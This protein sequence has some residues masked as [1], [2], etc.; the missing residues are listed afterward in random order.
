MCSPL[1]GGNATVFGLRCTCP[2][3]SSTKHYTGIREE[4][5][6]PS[7]LNPLKGHLFDTL[8]RPL[9][10]NRR[11]DDGLNW[12]QRPDLPWIMSC[13][14]LNKRVSEKLLPLFQSKETRF[15]PHTTRVP[16]LSQSRT[17]T[18]LCGR[19]RRSR[20]PTNSVE[21]STDHSG[22]ARKQEGHRSKGRR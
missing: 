4:G 20:K 14:Y 13:Q 17:T 10:Y 11:S 21:S 8:G 9:M 5:P 2:P 12:V 1:P 19:R 22:S 6:R 15:I 7:S 16:P 3:L 18:T